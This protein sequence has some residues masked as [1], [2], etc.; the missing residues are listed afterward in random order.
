MSKILVTGG[1]GFIGSHLVKRLVNLG[2]EVTVIDNFARGN[3]S[4]IDDVVDSVNLKD[5][6]LRYDFNKLLAASKKL[7]SYSTWLQ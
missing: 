6:D 7:I 3:S 1:V 5:L 2:H 4:R